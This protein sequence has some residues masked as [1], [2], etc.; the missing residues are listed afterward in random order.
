MSDAQSQGQER[1][2]VGQEGSGQAK[3]TFWRSAL[4]VGGKLYSGSTVL[5]WPITD[6]ATRFFVALYFFRSGSTKVGNWDAALLLAT[7]EY[8]VSWMTPEIAAA[9]GLAIE[10]IAP[11]LLFV[12]LLVRPAAAALAALTIISQLVYIP[13]TTNLMLIAALIWYAFCG[14]SALSIDRV[15]TSGTK[16]KGSL[17]MSWAVR[18]GA[19]LRKHSAAILLMVMRVWLGLAL[20]ALARVFEPS[21]MLA[22][23]LPSNAFAGLPAW[24]AIGCAILLFVGA[25]AT[26]VSYV[27]TFVIG[28]FMIA[29]AHPDV[30]F[31][32]ILLLAIYESRGAGL[33]SIDMAVE[34]WMKSRGTLQEVGQDE[35]DI[36][37][38]M[39]IWAGSFWV[40]CD[41]IMARWLS[42]K[43]K[44]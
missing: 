3:P 33:F 23:W 39:L 13:T 10:L 18:F 15:W 40:Y 22:T 5:F 25:A 35:E 26:L 4:N 16:V 34:R 9:S 7:E 8:P 31:Y 24:L 44:K 14:P 38:T 32:P 6:L 28:Y 20:L 19:L 17:F 36:A 37:V 11:L 12:G 27:L 21:V 41:R 43:P 30:T 29:S 42:S 2:Q 1:G